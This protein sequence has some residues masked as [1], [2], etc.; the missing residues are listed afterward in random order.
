MVAS[1]CQGCV[2]TGSKPKET[3]TEPRT[4]NLKHLYKQLDAHTNERAYPICMSMLVMQNGVDPKQLAKMSIPEIILLAEDLGNEGAAMSLHTINSFK[5]WKDYGCQVFSLDERTVDML[6][7]TKAPELSEL[8]NIDPYDQVRELRSD[9]DWKIPFPAFA[10]ELPYATSVPNHGKDEYFRV[11]IC[12]PYGNRDT[13]KAGWSLLYLTHEDVADGRTSVANGTSAVNSLIT[14]LCVYLNDGGQKTKGGKR[15]GY[16]KTAKK[17]KAK[18]NIWNVRTPTTTELPLGMAR[19]YLSSGNTPP[20][21]FKIGTRFMVRGH[22]RDQP[23]GPGNKDRRRT[24]IPPHMKGPEEGEAFS[25][26][27]KVK[28]KKTH[29]QENHD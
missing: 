13:G 16:D 18:V 26:I 21:T 27:Y 20:K 7:C 28:G 15:I 17:A 14:N 19:P 25:R 11:A 9:N 23:C 1:E 6:A 4:T 3:M 24:W 29:E 10:I 2:G 12:M 8:V 5:A 22:Y